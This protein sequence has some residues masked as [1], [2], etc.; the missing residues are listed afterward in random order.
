MKESEEASVHW[1]RQNEQAAGYWQ[2]K[3]L[4]VLFRVF[5]LF[6]LRIFAFPVGFFYFLF[7][8][9]GRTESQRFLQQIVPFIDDPR[10]SKKY[11]SP[12]ASMKHI[13]SFSL[14]MVEKLQSW[15]GKF[16]FENIH[17]QD[18]DIGDLIRELENGKGAFLVCS[19]L[20][21]AELLRGLTNF[22]RTGV[23]RKVPVTVIMDM[24]ATAHFNRMLKELNPQ[25]GIDIIGAREIGPQTAVLLED[26]LA[27]GG[28][29]AITGDRTTAEGGKNI[30]IPFLGKEA[31]FPSGA[32]YLASLMKSP[33]YFVFGLRRRD[34]SLMPEYDM[35][36]HKS[37]ISFDCSRKER[38]E[39]SLLLAHSFVSFLESYCKKQPF[40]WYNFFDFWQGGE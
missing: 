21:N 10:I 19:H 18:D 4:L 13:I 12:L 29:V 15:S 17:F 30:L 32:F 40:Q 28:L 20:G 37:S 24:N 8:K 3:L 14:S 36:V 39:R 33:V 26:R 5:P 25:F 38:L 9:R 2:L 11:C 16:S 7:S 31:P 34:F 35:H 27:A 23:S 1:S 22:D 6:I